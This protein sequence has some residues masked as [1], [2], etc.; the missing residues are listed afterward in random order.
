MRRTAADCADGIIDAG[1]MRSAQR[2]MRGG[3]NLLG[4]CVPN[5]QTCNDLTVQA[6]EVCEPLNTGCSVGE[7]YLG[8]TQCIAAP[9]DCNDGILDLGEACE[10]TGDGCGTNETCLACVQCVPLPTSC[11]N[12]ILQAGEACEL[13]ATVAH[14]ATCVSR[15]SECIGLSGL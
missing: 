9:I 1:E 3:G 8:C 10:L 14:S 2:R 11:G 12:G 15:L 6:A 13:P 5:P 4:M 7:V